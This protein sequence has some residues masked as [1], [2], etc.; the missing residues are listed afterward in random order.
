MLTVLCLLCPFILSGERVRFDEHVRPQ[1]TA[2]QIQTVSA[3]TRAGLAE[4]AA[5]EHGKKLIEKFSTSEYEIVVTEDLHEIS[6]GRAPQ[7]GLAIL[8]AADNRRKLKTYN[9]ILNP[10]F[11]EVSKDQA[12]MPDEPATP[13]DVMAAAFAAEM[14]HI[15]FY[16]RGISLPHHERPDFQREWRAIA[17]ELGMPGL[18]HDEYDDTGSYRRRRAPLV[19]FIGRE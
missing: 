13:A 3:A 10:T 4:W 12:P 18:R 19:Q 14:L 6:P 1:F 2:N 15:D 16:A 11:F 7:P 5:T 9:I 17:A 8:L